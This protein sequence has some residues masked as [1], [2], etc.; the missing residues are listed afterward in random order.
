MRSLVRL[1]FLL[2]VSLLA[3]CAAM[4]I[5]GQV[6]RGRVAL[7]A[8]D[9]EAALGYFLEAAKSDPQ[10]VYHYLGF[11]EGIWTYLGR[12]QYAT[13]RYGEARQSLER[14]LA[15]DE[16]DNLAR[17][18]LGLALARGGDYSA[19]LREITAAMKAIHEWLDYINDARRFEP[20]WDP[21]REMRGAI[22]KVLAETPGRAIDSA[23]LIATAEWLGERLEREVEFV[24]EDERRR[25]ER[26]R[27]ERER[28]GFSI[29]VGRGF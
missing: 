28:G 26:P 1:Q 3:A 7:S 29:G 11:S 15:T 27:F 16:Y 2:L 22:E 6:Q 25:F 5:A 9:H 20:R 17:L 24:R 19:G 12:A 4:Q 10:Y 8:R 14:A 13:G 21:A 18:Y 23:Q